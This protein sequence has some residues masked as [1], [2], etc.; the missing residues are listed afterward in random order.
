MLVSN[1]AEKIKEQKELIEGYHDDG[2]ALLNVAEKESRELTSE[3]QAQMDDIMS[4][5]E[6][7]QKRLATCEKQAEERRALQ[8]AKIQT[9]DSTFNKE[10]RNPT[11]R[12][13]LVR[14]K[15][16]CFQ[17]KDAEQD[18]FFAGK[19]LQAITAR[20]RGG[21]NEGAEA[22]VASRGWGHFLNVGTEGSPTAGGYL[23]P[24]PLSAAIINV[25][26]KSGVSRQ[27]AR[28]VPMTSDTLSI[29][30]KT[31]RTTVTYP[32]EATAITLSDQ[33][34]GQV[35][36]STKKRAVLSKVSQE[37]VDDAI[38]SI[39][40]DLAQEMG[41]DLA[42]QEDAEFIDGDGTSTYGGEVGLASIGSAGVSTAATGH[43]TWAEIDMADITA[44]MGLLPARFWG[45]EVSWICSANFYFSVMLRVL[46]S[47][48]GNT[49]A[50][51]EAGS[52]GRPTFLGAPV[53]F[54]HHM[55][56]ATAAATIHAYFGNFREAAIIGDR[57]GIRIGQ[58]DQYAFNEDVLTIRATARYDIN[59]HEP[60]TASVAGAYVALKSA[61]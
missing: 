58:S 36:L 14:A 49:I 7:A 41:S 23:V 24:D 52:T 22:F 47:A 37:L 56:V 29:P 19:W 55:P 42:I 15:L 26:E 1:L 33:T 11:P 3:E 45:P 59:V 46:A 13:N 4:N 40:D 28:V 2:Q 5:L 48:G 16:R 27:T 50:T 38:I 43:D 34:W 53:F 39:V 44:A 25:R 30:K 12:V 31:G 57:M 17:G 10:N 6:A 21:R 18:A 9:Y 60:G 35:A 8:L 61:S 54:S 32:G 20:M 51:I